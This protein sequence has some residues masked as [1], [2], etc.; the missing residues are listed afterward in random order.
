MRGDPLLDQALS[1]KYILAG[2]VNL[3]KIS[4]IVQLEID[5]VLRISSHRT[6]V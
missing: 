6:F 5:P 1:I 2:K 4:N 3:V